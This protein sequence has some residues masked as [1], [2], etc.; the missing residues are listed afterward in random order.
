MDVKDVNSLSNAALFSKISAFNTA[1]SGTAS[2]GFA[3]LLGQN[4]L[5]QD[6]IPHVSDSD[7]VT[8]KDESYVSKNVDKK[9]RPESRDAKKEAPVKERFVAKNKT[10]DSEVVS[11]QNSP[12]P[13]AAVVASPAAPVE[14]AIAP[15]VEVGGVDASIVA[16][17]VGTVVVDN[18]PVVGANLVGEGAEVLSSDIIVST[19]QGE[20]KLGDWALNLGDLAKM[21]VITLTNPQTG[22]I[23]QTTGAELAA[24]LAVQ[25]QALGAQSID[26]ISPDVK[27]VLND[28]THASKADSAS[29]IAAK[30]PV[31]TLNAVIEDGVAA[32]I[33]APVKAGGSAKPVAVAAGVVDQ[34]VDDATAEQGAQLADMLDSK[35]KIKVEVKVNGEKVAYH[36]QADLVKDR[37]ALDKAVAGAFEMSKATPNAT[38]VSTPSTPA[39][40]A[41]PVAT[42]ANQLSLVPAMSASQMP[43]DV[44]EVAVKSAKGSVVEQIGAVT[45]ASNAAVSA[46]GSEFVNTAKAEAKAADVSFKDV[47]K[48]L[49]KEAVEQVK[50]NIT[51]SAVKGVDTIDVRLKPEEL[52]HIEIKMHIKDGKMQAHIISSRP[53][54]LEVLQKEAQALE[55]A[56]NDAGFQT[57]EGSLSFSFREGGSANQQQ[58]RNPGL[59][60][61][62]GDVFENEASNELVNAEPAFQGWTADKGLN[63]RV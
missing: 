10:T 23:T 20:A 28:V 51:K 54:T 3:S 30:A 56:F 6:L 35:T 26:T 38:T 22:E 47:Y 48:G 9:V 58:E 42:N 60:N 62:I 13:E 32:P 49:S 24:K 11:V 36:A 43:I 25:Q 61:F 7:K 8:V 21:G 57:D 31:E 52:G 40:T 46:S 45:T 1:N 59:R 2:S 18:T 50:V 39:S 34:N 37:A 14:E 16:K 33:V 55:K 15:A 12:T 63:I 53:E 27:G 5:A 4:N 29:Q 19:P 41:T 17:E 44:A